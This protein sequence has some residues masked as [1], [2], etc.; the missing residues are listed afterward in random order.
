MNNL[1]KS[2][3]NKIDDFKDL[4]KHIG[5]LGVREPEEAVNHWQEDTYFG[6]LYLAG[7]NP[8]HL[9]ICKKVKRIR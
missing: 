7:T 1:L 6:W 2:K 8:N 3:L 4:F 5:N 9:T